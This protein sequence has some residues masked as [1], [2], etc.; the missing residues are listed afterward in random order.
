MKTEQSTLDRI[1]TRPR[2][3][4]YTALTAEQYAENLK[5][6]IQE[7]HEEFRGNINREVATISIKTDEDTYYKPY[8]SLRIEK[9][10]D[11][12]E[13]TVIRGVFGP[14]S[15]VWTFFMFLYFLWG[16]LWMT[17]FT[18]WFVEKQIKSSEFPWALSASFAVLLFAI[19]TYSAARYGQIK[20]KEEMALLRKFAI[21]STLP[22]EKISKE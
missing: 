5:K 7:H 3:K 8:L 17:F 4:M 20:A 2:F 18:M 14:S 6:F 11:I 15:A 21:E 13:N 9:E 16:V 19:C 1:R 12:N 10:D 22:H